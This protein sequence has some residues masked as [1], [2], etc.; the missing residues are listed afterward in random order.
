MILD[1]L[2]THKPK[3]DSWLR[4]H[5]NV[6]CHY[7]PTHES[8]LSQIEIWFSILAGKSLKKGSFG[9][10]RELINHIDS[11]IAGYNDRAR[12]FFWTK[13]L[14]HQIAPQTRFPI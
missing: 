2:S 3:P 5:P 10:V 4:R 9:S 1:N 12:P 11:F 13:S 7:I 8:W 14:G 6:H